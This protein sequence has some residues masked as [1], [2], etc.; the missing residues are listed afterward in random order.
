MNRKLLRLGWTIWGADSG[1]GSAGLSC[2]E[3][4]APV[5][6]RSPAAAV[7]ASVAARIA[8][9][10]STPLL[11]RLVFSQSPSPI[12]RGDPLCTPIHPHGEIRKLRLGGRRQGEGP[13]SLVMA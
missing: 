4:E 7:A 2:A 13:A 11:P 12:D 5:A 10:F 8:P 1:G 3:T 6:I 9:V